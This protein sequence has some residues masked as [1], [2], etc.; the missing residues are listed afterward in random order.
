MAIATGTT[1]ATGST[2]SGIVKAATGS[3]TGISIDIPQV[4]PATEDKKLYFKNGTPVKLTVRIL[5][6]KTEIS[7]ISAEIVSGL[8]KIGFAIQFEEVESST[9]SLVESKNYETKNYDIFIT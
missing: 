7:D 9:S 1:V 8:E 2:G 5:S 6:P 3:A 4:A